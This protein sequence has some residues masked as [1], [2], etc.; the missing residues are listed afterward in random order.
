MTTRQIQIGKVIGTLMAKT[1]TTTMLIDPALRKRKAVFFVGDSHALRTFR[2]TGMFLELSKYLKPASSE[3]VNE[4]LIF[5]FD[6]GV[7]H[8]APRT[9]LELIPNPSRLESIEFRRAAFMS[10]VVAVLHQIAETVVRREKD[11]EAFVFISVGAWDILRPTL[12]NNGF[13]IDSLFGD[14]WKVHQAKDRQEVPQNGDGSN[15]LKTT[16]NEEE[17]SE[18]HDKF[19]TKWKDSC[20][21]INT[22]LVNVFGWGESVDE[23]HH[24]RRQMTNSGVFNR[25]TWRWPGRPNCSAPRF[26]SPR[27]TPILEAACPLISESWWPSL[28]G[29]AMEVVRPTEK[30]PAVGAQEHHDVANDPIFEVYAERLK[31]AECRDKVDGVHPSHMCVAKEAGS[32]LL[33]VLS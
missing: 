17:S 3:Y 32:Y 25:V 4:K 23:D 10:D 19:L 29:T 21:R 2:W 12:E 7:F 33:R 8:D 15:Q 11:F 28:R 9:K 18:V 26:Q 13:T 22:A 31:S 27:A 14:L 1:L 20:D 24:I 30:R 6:L 5:N 16:F